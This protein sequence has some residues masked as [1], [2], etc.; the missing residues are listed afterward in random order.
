MLALV[1]D[2]VFFNESGETATSTSERLDRVIFGSFK[3]EVS[4][5]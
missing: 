4:V 1:A 5:Q 2:L 3:I